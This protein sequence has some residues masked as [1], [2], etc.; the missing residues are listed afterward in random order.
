MFATANGGLPDK[1]KLAFYLSL[2]AMTLLFVT[3]CRYEMAA[4]LAR[5][6]VRTLKRRLGGEDVIVPNGR[7]AA[8]QV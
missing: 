3:L 4:K 1:M 8:P 5:G 6:R 7:S 2:L